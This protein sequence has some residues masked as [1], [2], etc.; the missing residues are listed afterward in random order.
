MDRIIQKLPY[1]ASLFKICIV[2]LKNYDLANTGLFITS[3]SVFICCP[4]CGGLNHAHEDH[5]S[6]GER[7]NQYLI[8][9]NLPQPD[10]EFTQ[11]GCTLWP[12][13]LPWH[14]FRAPCLTHDIAYWAGGNKELQKETNLALKDSIRHTGP[15]GPILGP[16]M[17][18]GVTYF[19]DNGISRVINSHWG[20][21]WK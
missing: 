11:D 16:I 18:I 14:D 13:K 10:Y 21:G 4:L 15:L 7:A 5:S 9:N 2:K 17:Y 19:G 8:D 20:Y 3:F 12:D 6:T 1:F